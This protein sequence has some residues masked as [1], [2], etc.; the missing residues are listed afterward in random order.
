MKKYI[1]PYI[2]IATL[3]CGCYHY[4]RQ[5]DAIEMPEEVDSHFKESSVAVTTTETETSEVVS[6]ISAEET[7]EADT[8]T[9][10]AI[11]AEEAQILA[12]NG[13]EYV[14][15]NNALAIIQN[16]TYGEVTRLIPDASVPD[17]SDEA[18]AEWL[19]KSWKEGSHHNMNDCS[20]FFLYTL[21]DAESN[22][23]DFSCQNPKPMTT[24]EVLNLNA[25]LKKSIEFFS[26]DEGSNSLEGFSYPEIIDG[27]SFDMVYEDGTIKENKKMYV[28]K[29]SA[30][31]DY[32]FD[33]Y[34][35]PYADSV[36]GFL[37]LAQL[38]ADTATEPVTETEITSP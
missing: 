5:P 17:R 28:L 6:E 20:P 24:V 37:A 10:P 19:E 35:A 14:H 29:T 38:A 2:L 31:D 36:V 26:E 1:I 9:T 22:F 23:F 8:P 16:T 27:Y 7:T 32:R 4:H 12:D 3:F 18:L 25:I 30:S 15:T 33:L 34:Y 11:S 21:R 13:M